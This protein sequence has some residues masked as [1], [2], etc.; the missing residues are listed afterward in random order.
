MRILFLY[1]LLSS[2]FI[3]CSPSQ[4]EVTSFLGGNPDYTE[5]VQIGEQ[6][7]T[8]NLIIG[9]SENIEITISNTSD[10]DLLAL[11]L[12]GF[13]TSFTSTSLG[14]CTD[15]LAPG[16]VCTFII[17]FNSP[18]GAAQLIEQ[19]L[20]LS[21]TAAGTLIEKDFKVQGQTAL[22]EVTVAPSY[23]NYG[24]NWNDYV[25][26]DGAGIYSATDSACQPGVDIG[27]KT[28]LHG[29]EFK[30]AI[31]SSITTCADISVFD[32]LDVFSWECDDSSVPVKVVSHFLKE[33]KSLSDLIDATPKTFKL[34]KVKIYHKDILVAQSS[35]SSW[36]N[37]P[38]LDLP[39]SSAGMTQ[40]PSDTTEGKIFILSSDA[41]GYGYNITEN[42][43]SLVIMPTARFI[44][45]SAASK[46]F[47]TT[48]GVVGANIDC[49]L[50][51]S[52]VNHLW[53]EGKFFGISG[54]SNYG[55]N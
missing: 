21:F 29:G 28:C 23:P 27:Y 8:S 26:N 43:T 6:A 30:K 13:N 7:L 39:D 45:S 2:L 52:G 10:Q 32:E 35:L 53:L 31:I 17:Q 54:T 14:T 48:G 36:W 1:S 38:I 12:M 40:L 25:K 18:G 22:A 9:A 15:R 50:T 16:E 46:C 55:L 34:N 20:K 49:I 41:S 24:V 4:V 5:Q 11:E 42:K 37:N 33:K 3:S 44:Q 51:T 47:S 19:D